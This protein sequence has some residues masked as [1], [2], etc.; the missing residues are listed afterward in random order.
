MRP[1]LLPR[2]AFSV[3]TTREPRLQETGVA[4]IAL[5]SVVRRELEVAI[6][7]RVVSASRESAA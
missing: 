6:D 1:L 7:P 2:L 3:S 4:L 5:A